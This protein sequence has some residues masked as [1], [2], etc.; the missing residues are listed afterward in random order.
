MN[1]MAARWLCLFLQNRFLDRYYGPNGTNLALN[2][3]ASQELRNPDRNHDVGRPLR[4]TDR[5]YEQD[6]DYDISP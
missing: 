5:D 6:Y 2:E 3:V 4:T 1:S